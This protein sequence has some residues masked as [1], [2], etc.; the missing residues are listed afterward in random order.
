MSF[1]VSVIIPAY[2][3][4]QT[5]TKTLQS[6]QEQTFSDW[7]A[8]VVND[9]STDDTITVVEAFQQQEQRI[10]LI[11][12]KNQGLSGAR[13]TGV[14]HSNY[15]L[16]LFLDA[17][18]WIY[19]QHLEKLTQK[20]KSDPSLD[21]V[22][23]GWA[24][25]TPKGEVVSTNFADLTGD[26]FIPFTEYCVSVVHTFLVPKYL[27]ETLG[28]FDHSLRSCEDWA[29]W[30]RIARTGVRFGAVEDV[31]AAYRM[32]PNSMSRNGLQLLQ[33]GCMVLERGHT[34]DPLLP[35]QHPVY[36]QGAPLKNLIR[37][38][39]D[40]LYAC[41]GYLIGGGKD[42]REL[43]E[44]IPPTPIQLNPYTAANCILT[45]ALVTTAVSSQEWYQV[46]PTFQNNLQS[47]LLALEKHSGTQNFAQKTYWL[48]Q[49]LILQRARDP[50]L[51]RTVGTILANIELEILYKFPIN[52]HL[53]KQKLKYLIWVT[54]LLLPSWKI[55]IQKL[56]HLLSSP[57]KNT[58]SYAVDPQH[59]FEEMFAHNATPW[60][61]DYSYE[62]HK[63]Q[64]TL[65]ILPNEEIVSA[66]EVACAEG[67]FTRLLAP[68]VNQLLATDISSTAVQRTQSNCSDLPNVQVKCLDF[69]Q[70][71]LPGKF[72]LIVCSE[73]LYYLPN[74][75]A[76]QKVVQ[77]FAQALNPGGYILML[78]SN[79]I[80]DDPEH[81]GFDWGHDFGGKIIGE[82]FAHHRELEYVK[83]LQ[84]PLYRIQLFQ[85][86]VGRKHQ[87]IKTPKVIEKAQYKNLPP[88]IARHIIWK[89]TRHLPILVYEQI[90]LHSFAQQ[91][92][93]FHEQGYETMS[94][95]QWFYALGKKSFIPGKKVLIAFFNGHQEQF[96]EAWSVLKELGLTA[97]IFLYADEI[98]QLTTLDS[99][100][101]K[102]ISL[103]PWKQVR[104]M[105]SEGIEFGCHGL[106]R[107]DDLTKL[108]VPKL[109]N[110][111]TRSREILKKEL[112]ITIQDF[113]Y[114]Q[115]KFNALLQYLVGLSGYEYAITKKL[116]LATVKSCQ[117][118]IPSI[119]GEC[120]DNLDQLIAE[121]T[122]KYKG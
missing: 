75:K 122:L 73:V 32:S 28:K 55:K 66:L 63:Y 87:L 116:G 114:A 33:S 70:E 118:A 88:Q 52:L 72:D 44:L 10:R 5:I 15:D 91:M 56:K 95:S 110:T 26:L 120:Q 65:S 76:L 58:E 60:D 83:E 96:N 11:N 13:N 24:Y 57:P 67:D 62:K 74:Q 92:R 18:D 48:A 79:C 102:Q 93:Y 31:L 71:E 38:K 119:P 37:N 19:P 105:Q 23:C 47:F 117:L 4:A 98:G 68:R 50:R 22:Y 97:T 40:L 41:A 51:S 6:L 36:P 43:L 94:L 45:H 53:T 109:H 54:L 104:K 16:L 14:I 80:D 101:G 21:V 81:P 113:A 9:G 2:N 49:K 103:I 115:G 29:L 12:Q 77:K 108:S 86:Q 3:G 84:T 7:E 89:T 106:N 85:R 30:Q 35:T 99:L 111:L 90:E 107:Y 27:V 112:A 1:Q 20:L 39:F 100:T 121:L 59:H 34:P 64:L 42:A 25:V 78:H 82:T 17:D 61:Y 8:I 46:W 69:L